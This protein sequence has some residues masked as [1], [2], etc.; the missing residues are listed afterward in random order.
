M[1]FIITPQDIEISS[2]IDHFLTLALKTSKNQVSQAISN[3]LVLHNQRRCHKGGIMLKSGDCIEF[4]VPDWSET[5]CNATISY[6]QSIEVLYEDEDVLILNKPSSLVVHNAP[7]V[8]EATLVDYLRSKGYKLS[9][10]SGDER[11]GIV[12]RLDKPTSGAIAIAKNNFTHLHL[13]QQL[14]EKTMGRYY[15]A[16]IDLPLKDRMDVECL[17]GRN[18][19]NRLKMAK[20]QT[21]RFSKTSFY[22]L[23]SNQLGL[24]AAKLHTGRTHQIRLHLETLSRHIIGDELYGK[25][26]FYQMR[27]ML[28]AY[29]LYFIHPRTQKTHIICAPLFE[30]MLRFMQ[31]NF[32]LE[33]VNEVVDQEHILHCFGNLI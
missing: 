11:Y 13:S 9:N 2:R 24:I 17:M 18:P 32:G 30:D 26:D 28:H 29:L 33:A 8:K 1:K 12:H 6:P 21:G 16:I 7:S 23:I 19:N 22:P 15:I 31:E 25:K 14:Q 27:L 3:G 4:V 20:L 10:L 5:N